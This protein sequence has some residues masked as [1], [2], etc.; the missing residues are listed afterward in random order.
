[1]GLRPDTFQMRSKGGMQVEL[2][3]QQYIRVVIDHS[4]LKQGAAIKQLQVLF[5]DL[6]I[7]MSIRN[8]KQVRPESWTSGDRTQALFRVRR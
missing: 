8:L 7:V 1:M 3:G 5:A 4:E 2:D 6:V